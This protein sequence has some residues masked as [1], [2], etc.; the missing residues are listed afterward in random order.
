MPTSFCY[1]L[2]DAYLEHGKLKVIMFDLSPE[3]KIALNPT[4]IHET[5]HTLVFSQKW[6]PE[7]SANVLECS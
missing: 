7:E 1:A 6:T 5:Y 2:D 3:N 4:M